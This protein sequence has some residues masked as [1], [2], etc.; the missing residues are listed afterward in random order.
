MHSE[1][2]QLLGDLG[3]VR[4]PGRFLYFLAYVIPVITG[5]FF[6]LG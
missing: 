2:F 6:G 4:V 3:L 1:L 5:Q